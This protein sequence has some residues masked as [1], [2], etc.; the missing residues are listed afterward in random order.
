MS[1]DI[2]QNMF[3]DIKESLDLISKRFH[4]IESEA[5]FLL[6]DEGLEKLDS[7]SMRLQVVGETL[8]K[9]YKIDKNTLAKHNEIEW[10]KIIGLRDIISHN[11]FDIDA[12]IIFDICKNHIPNLE[13]TV[14]KIIYELQKQTD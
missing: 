2:I 5:D 11:Y 8:K 3:L 1:K 14:N 7:I 6:S 13:L 4:K 9:L 12:E 10:K